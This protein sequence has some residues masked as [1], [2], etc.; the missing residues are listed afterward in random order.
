MVEGASRQHGSPPAYAPEIV[1]R[2]T[3]LGA[4]I[5]RDGEEVTTRI[6]KGARAFGCL[7]MSVFCDEVL[8]VATK[9]HVYRT[10]VLSVL[11]YGAE[12]WH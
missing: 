2:F 9:R 11:L 7:R 4:E 5:C 6:A 1:D 3:Y 12:T 10:A 8:S